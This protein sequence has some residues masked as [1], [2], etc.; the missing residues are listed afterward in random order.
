MALVVIVRRVAPIEQRALMGGT[1]QWRWGNASMLVSAAV[2]S[3]GVKAW[4]S[5]HPAVLIGGLAVTLCIWRFLL[6]DRTEG[7]RSPTGSALRTGGR[8]SPR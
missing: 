6:S 2:L 8:L 7:G 1:T 4:S 5:P 3:G